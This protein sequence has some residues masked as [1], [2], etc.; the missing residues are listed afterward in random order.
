MAIPKPVSRREFIHRFRELG[1]SGPL[2][3]GRHQYMT[4]GRRKIFIPNPHRGDIGIVL[5]K[6]ILKDI[7]IS[8][9][10]FFQS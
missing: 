1:F 2:V 5:L 9:D 8:A 3:G 10:E 7:G 6:R 4:R